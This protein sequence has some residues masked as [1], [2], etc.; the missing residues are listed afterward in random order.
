MMGVA[1]AVAAVLL[2]V[3]VYLGGRGLERKENQP[4]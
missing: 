4:K 2:G 1:Q 3:S